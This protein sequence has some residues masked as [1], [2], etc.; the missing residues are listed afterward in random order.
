MTQSLDHTPLEAQSL[1]PEALRALASPVSK[2]MAARGLAPIPNPRDLVAVLYQLAID[3][4]DK[5]SA[6]ARKSVAELPE[7]LVR[8]GLGDP[9]Q[10]SRVLDLLAGMFRGEL[11]EIIVKNPRTHPI[12]I[13]RIAAVGDER[14]CDVIADNQERLLANPDIIGALY[15]N[16]AARM[17]TVDR[18]VELA[19]RRGVK[20]AGIAAWDELVK[21]YAGLDKG[22][23]EPAKA[24]DKGGELVEVDPAELDAMFSAAVARN[25]GRGEGAEAAPTEVV[26]A[27][28]EA[29]E[30]W[31]LPVPVKL[32]LAILG[33][34]FDR[35]VLIRDPK[36]IVSSAVI[37]SPGVSEIEA[38]K[39]AGNNGLSEEVIAYI[40]NKREWTKL[41]N[42][43]FSLVNNPKCPLPSAMRL[44]PLLREK[45]IQHVARSKGIPSAL[46]AQARKLMQ[47]KASGGKGGG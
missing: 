31:M 6:A 16:R 3:P 17:S 45:D 39:Y 26:P 19:V 5:L 38:A 30:I 23:P 4:D 44:L 29:K 25:A 13:A 42:I 24:T 8:A 18:V 35:A 15:G 32:R 33:N 11:V 41:Y 40:A 9:T 1:G 21:V 34:A 27:V 10:D 28:E 20:V 12:T 37:K 36:K 47:A 2:L 46:A 22:A 43:K 14:L 7:P